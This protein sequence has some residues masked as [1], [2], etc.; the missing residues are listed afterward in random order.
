[1]SLEKGQS[2]LNMLDAGLKDEGVHA[3]PTTLLG[4]TFQF[5][6]AWGSHHEILMGKITGI[7][8]SDEGGLDFYVS[9][10]RFWGKPLIS[11]KR[12]NGKWLAY[13]RDEDPNRR[14]YEGEFTIVLG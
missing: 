13:I 8:L 10:P 4:S 14:F 9:C 6:A 3:S 11:I 12:N 2:F 5:G 1:M 7:G